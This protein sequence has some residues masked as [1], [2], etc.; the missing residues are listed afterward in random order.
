MSWITSI[1]KFLNENLG[2]VTFVVGFLAIYLYI[3]QKKDRKRDAAR[4][5]MQEIRYA[6]QQI[7]HAKTTEPST[8]S[9]AIKLL[10]TNSWNENIHLFTKD[11][12]ETELDLIS[13]FYSRATY[14][15]F[16]IAERSKQKINPPPA[17]FIPVNIP[18]SGSVTAQPPLLPG[19][20]GPQQVTPQPV[21]FQGPALGELFT[22]QLIA[23]M[24][25]SVE[26][27]YNTPA[28][29][30]LRKISERKWYQPV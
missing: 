19:G 15:D 22:I 18:P 5:I 17:Q 4:L 24:S 1:L 27:L 23:Q 3:K 14:I 16:L 13:A 12:K 29:E 28:V 30:K 11:L 25:S 8:Y 6:E 9:L 26:F 10:P 2:T 7:R 21:V 20:G